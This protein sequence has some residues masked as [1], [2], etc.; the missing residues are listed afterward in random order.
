MQEDQHPP[1]N[2]NEIQQLVK[3][4]VDKHKLANSPENQVLDLTSEVG[5]LAKEVLKMTNYG[6]ESLQYRPEMETEVGDVFYVLISIA[7][8]YNINL[9]NA[10]NQVLLKYEQRLNQGSAGSGND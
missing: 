6:T 2:L 5:E 3:D 7:N 9:A 1:Q 8:E 10:L 4:F